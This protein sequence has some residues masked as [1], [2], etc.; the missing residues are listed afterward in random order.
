MK[1][2]LIAARPGVGVGV[3]YACGYGIHMPIR[4]LSPDLKP[5]RNFSHQPKFQSELA[6]WNEFAITTIPSI[7]MTSLGVKARN[8]TSGIDATVDLFYKSAE[9]QL[10]V[11]ELCKHIHLDYLL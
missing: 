6:F 5:C 10:P 9:C 1:V 3:S 7:S 2:N 4:T 8:H 11:C